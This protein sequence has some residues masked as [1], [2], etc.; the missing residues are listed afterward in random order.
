MTQPQATSLAIDSVD[1]ATSLLRSRW[2]HMFDPLLP[3]AR[4]IHRAIRKELGIE[5]RGDEDLFLREALRLHA[6]RP[7]YIAALATAKNRINLDGTLGRLAEA[8]S[9]A[10]KERLETGSTWEDTSRVKRNR[11]LFAAMIERRGAPVSESL[12]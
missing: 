2:P 11:E 5:R 9:L 1:A 8:E 6:A 3:L 10:A 4:N 7:E 12:A